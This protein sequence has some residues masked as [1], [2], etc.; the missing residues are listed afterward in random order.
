MKSFEPNVEYFLLRNK[1]VPSL[2]DVVEVDFMNEI[3][4]IYQDRLDFTEAK[5]LLKTLRADPED[6]F[7]DYKEDNYEDIFVSQVVEFEKA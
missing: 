4:E 5:T 7:E 2:Y 6:D 1:D 3:A